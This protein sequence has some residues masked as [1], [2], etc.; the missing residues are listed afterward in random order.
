MRQDSDY[1]RR[2]LLDA[3]LDRSVEEGTLVAQNSLVVKAMLA[4][5]TG[6]GL[7]AQ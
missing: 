4:L 6:D 7:S 2:R 5:V 3:E 1:F